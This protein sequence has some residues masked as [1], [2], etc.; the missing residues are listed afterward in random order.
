MLIPR[1]G[2]VRHAFA[3]RTRLSQAEEGEIRS[4]LGAYDLGKLTGYNR[5]AI[6]S[7]RSQ[8]LILS[9]EK[10][11]KVLKRYKYSLGLEA[12]TYEHSVLRHLAAAGFPC[13]RLVLN[14]I[15]ETCTEREG[16]YYAITDFISGVKYTDFFV[17][18]QKKTELVEEAA[19]TLARYHQLIEGVVPEGTKTDGF[20]PGSDRRWQECE[21]HLAELD[22]Y[23][24]LF[25][26]T[27]A[28]A[29]ECFFLRNMT[30]FKQS[31]ID[32][33]QRLSQSGCF[34]PKLV[35]HGDYGPYNILFDKR[36]MAAVLDFECTHLDWR[37]GE[38]ISAMC[39]FSGKRDGIDRHQAKTFLTT[40]HSAHALTADE[41][42][43]M[44]DI[45]R[46]LRLRGLTVY[47]G[48]YFKLG[49]P[50]KLGGARHSVWWMDWM[51]QNGTRLIEELMQ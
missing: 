31:L 47:F 8:N 50:A 17:T 46:F 20:V 22:R 11:R 49:A 19:R 27:S 13:P 14:K 3:T 26:E 39:R 7:T 10:G 40:Y 2:K 41:I 21:W 16:S 5:P 6:G 24:S 35:V 25:K 9:T 1:P 28:T 45:L 29:L 33:D 38:V 43:L 36:R 34:L 4:I 37:A 48:A 12:I 32:L 51:Q 30:R 18:K 15:G 42:A 44:P 23:E